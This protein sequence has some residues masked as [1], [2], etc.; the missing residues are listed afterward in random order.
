ME[1]WRT[2]PGTTFYEASSTGRVRSVDHSADY[3]RRPGFKMLVR[4]RVLRPFD[5]GKYLTVV[6]DRKARCV[7]ELVT[8]AFHGPAPTPGLEVRHKN[9]RRLDNSADNL[10]W[11]T[12]SQ[13]QNDRFDHGT[14]CEG[15]K[16]YR[17]ILTDDNVRQ[18]MA[19]RGK[20]GPTAIA[21]AVGCERHLV[22]SVIYGQSWNWLTQLPRER[23][24]Y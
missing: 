3:G 22:K 14:A 7:H 10:A 6:I 19:L 18:I 23:R 21:K 2:I 15:E 13:N 16:N 11:G 4:G 1:V 9:G 12:R 24:S 17:A 5:N 8:L 20:L